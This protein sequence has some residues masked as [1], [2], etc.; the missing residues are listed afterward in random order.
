MYHFYS[1]SGD[2][3]GVDN[4]M[5]AVTMFLQDYDDA[6]DYD[7]LNKIICQWR[8]NED[9]TREAC[10][11]PSVTDEYPGCYYYTRG[12]TQDSTVSTA[13]VGGARNLRANQDLPKPRPKPLSAHDLII[14]NYEQS[15]IDENYIPKTI[16]MHPDDYK[17]EDDFDW[18]D[19]IAQQYQKEESEPNAD[20][21]HRHLE[22]YDHVGPWF[23]YFPMLGVKTEYYFRYS[24]SQ[25]IPPCYGDFIPNNN[26]A[27]TNNWRIMKDPLRVSHRQINEMHRLLRERIAPADDPLS[28]CKPD[29]A[30]KQDPD[31]PTK[32]WV[33]RPL[34]STSNAHHMTFC[35]CTNWASK[36]YEDKRWCR[37]HQDKQSRFYEHPYGFDSAVF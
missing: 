24:G 10:G 8:K 6:P 34:Q 37:L 32:V 29:T 33:A 15:L 30:A 18:D 21:R 22:N 36:F 1:I 3:A 14:H 7:M 11:L 9:Q 13:S 2:A 17:D 19:F 27:R 16:K 31:D 20:E 28:A 25:T 26:R 4:E 5:A 12:H 23:N 35:E